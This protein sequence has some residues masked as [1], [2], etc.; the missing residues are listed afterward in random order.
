MKNRKLIVVCHNYEPDHTPRKP[1]PENRFF[2]YG[3]GGNIGKNVKHYNPDYEV[4]VWRLDRKVDKYYEGK[5]HGVKFRV[6][7]S[8]NFKNL[9]D[10]SFKFYRELKKEVKKNGEL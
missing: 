9:F 1:D 3:F 6:F 5:V 8:F 7:K 10:F 4:E 2:T